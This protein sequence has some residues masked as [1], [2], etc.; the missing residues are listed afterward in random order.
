MTTKA[1][2][3]HPEN[4]PS[5]PAAL[6]GTT[7]PAPLPRAGT[8]SQPPDQPDGSAS[9]AAP[10]PLTRT[11]SLVA[12]DLSVPLATEESRTPRIEIAGIAVKETSR[13]TTHRALQL[14]KTGTCIVNGA[15]PTPVFHAHDSSRPPSNDR[16]SPHI[17]GCR[18]TVFQH[19][20][21]YRHL[22]LAGVAAKCSFRRAARS[23]P[24]ALGDPPFADSVAGPRAQR[25][26]AATL[27]FP[28][29]SQPP[30]IHFSSVSRKLKTCASS[31]VSTAAVPK[32]SVSPWT[33]PE[34][35]SRAAAGLLR[36]PRASDS[37]Q[38]RTA[39]SR[40][41]R[42]LPPCSPNRSK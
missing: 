18:K 31:W 3:C 27:A 2:F 17:R 13:P 38:P 19:E 10:A 24:V 9:L 26:S 1:R 35:S 42:L 32:P 16:R 21:T 33:C 22:S 5:H 7:P 4:S 6:A 20:R 11:A 41:P 40:R 29:S 15:R 39:S 23:P 28:N 25:G 8:Q 30:F 14:R 37:N 34:L 12:G 36:I